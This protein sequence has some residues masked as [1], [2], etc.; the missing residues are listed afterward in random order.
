MAAAANAGVEFPTPSRA[1]YALRTATVVATLAVL[2]YSGTFV[3]GPPGIDPANLALVAVL[4]PAFSYLIDAFVA[5]VR[6][7]GE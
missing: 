3:D 5:N 7:S 1:D 6:R 2:Q 4:F